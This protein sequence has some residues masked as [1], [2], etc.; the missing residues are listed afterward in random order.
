MPLFTPRGAPFP[1]ET[2]APDGAAQIQ[3]LAEFV[4]FLPGISTL[5]YAQISALSGAAAF[6]GRVVFQGDTGTDRP[7]T[8]LYIYNSGAGVWRPPWNTSWGVVLNGATAVIND[9]GVY[10]GFA[11]VAGLPV[12]FNAIANR[13]YEILFEYPFHCTTAGD[14][15]QA[16]ILD[17]ATPIALSSYGA[18][19]ASNGHVILGKTVTF[20]AAGTHVI[21]PQIGHVSAGNVAKRASGAECKLTIKDV[22]SAGAP[23]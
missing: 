5:S 3:E 17:G 6:N 23:A 2:D 20:T 8:G 13:W 11:T 12:T 1:A 4:D 14:G 10:T 22:G 19:G 15:A 16:Q 21:N 9:T 7:Q 18:D